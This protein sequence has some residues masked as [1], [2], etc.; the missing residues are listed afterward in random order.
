MNCGQA[1]PKVASAGIQ[2]DVGQKDG[3]AVSVDSPVNN[4]V[5]SDTQTMPPVRDI[6][7]MPVQ[8][9]PIQPP[10]QQPIQPQYPMQPPYPPQPGYGYGMPQAPKKSHT[11]QILV[12]VVVVL[13]L[14]AVGA[15]TYV[16]GAEDRYVGKC[17]NGEK[18]VT[19]VQSLLK[20]TK[21]LNGDP[22]ADATKDYL[23]R[24]GKAKENLDKFSHELKTTRT[25]NKYQAVNKKLVE[26]VGLE[27]SMLDDVETVIKAPLDS[28]SKDAVKRVQINVKELADR[29]GE[30]DIPKTDF[31]VSMQL[32]G[33]NDDLNAYIRK[34]QGLEEQ[35]KAAAEQQARAAE[36][37]RLQ[38][39]KDRQ[40]QRMQSII[41]GTTT[42]EYI[43]TNVRRTSSSRLDFEGFFYN[44]TST[45]LQKID[46]MELSVSLYLHGEKV[47]Q[48]TYNFYN[49]IYLGRLMPHQRQSDSLWCTD[50]G[51][52][53][54]FDEYEVSSS[55]V[56]YTYWRN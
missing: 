45:P 12:A 16:H 15:F 53:P 32:N 36:A 25:G 56:N 40:A 11:T 7:P 27:R 2:S 52:I 3:Q 30:I 1:K 5:S 39:I 19:D 38:G 24:L 17:V 33:L 14:A 43:A 49:T 6:A 9:Q 21:D 46:S 47:Y 13:L 22:D 8:Q 4:K 55:D 28:G 18:A 51:S 31:A 35:K 48:T 44:G 23:V 20:E 34:K 37:S 29:A 41:N 10:I 26:A 54:E 42:V 50:S